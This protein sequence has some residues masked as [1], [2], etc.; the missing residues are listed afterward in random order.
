MLK[1]MKKVGK[2][3]PKNGKQDYE[4]I[5]FQLKCIP[6]EFPTNQSTTSSRLVQRPAL[7]TY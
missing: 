6:T 4:Y 3:L 2:A 5:V 7:F 1:K